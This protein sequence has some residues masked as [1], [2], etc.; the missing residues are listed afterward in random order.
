MV[1]RHHQERIA[2]HLREQVRMAEVQPP[3]I[4]DFAV[5]APSSHLAIRDEAET[6]LIHP[7]QQEPSETAQAE[8]TSTVLTSPEPAPEPAPG[9]AAQP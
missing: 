2:L 8:A 7:A 3:S 6:P 9:R 5:T 1:D 4:Q